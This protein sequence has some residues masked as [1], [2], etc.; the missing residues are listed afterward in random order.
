MLARVHVEHELSKRA[1][2]TRQTFFQNDEPRAGKLRRGLE[3]HLAERLAQFEMLLGG[4]R[5]VALSPKAMM[6]D[7]VALVRAV[8]HIVE[9]QIGN[10]ASAFRSILELLPLFCFHL[11]FRA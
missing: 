7:V 11:P 10:F 6:L 9:R 3:I 8:R 5:I 1:F 4:K 2:E